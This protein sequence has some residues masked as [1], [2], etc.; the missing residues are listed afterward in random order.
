[1]EV[2]SRC[3]KNTP[4]HT[5]LYQYTVKLTVSKSTVSVNPFFSPEKHGYRTGSR[6]GSDGGADA[7][8]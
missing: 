6:V 8:Y 2:N 3:R 7:V 5:N 4:I 1:M